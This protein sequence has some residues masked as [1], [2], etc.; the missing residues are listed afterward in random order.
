MFCLLAA[1]LRRMGEKG[2]DPRRVLTNLAR[3]VGKNRLAE[4]QVL[5]E[6]SRFRQAVPLGLM[7]APL[8]LLIGFPAW[9]SFSR[10]FH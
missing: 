1:N 7:I 9:V 2:Q 8:L 4:M 3:T 5:S 10:A 6:R